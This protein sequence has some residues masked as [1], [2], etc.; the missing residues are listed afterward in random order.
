MTPLDYQD[1]AIPKC[2]DF[3]EIIDVRSPDEFLVDHIPGALNF[4]VLD[5]D[6]RKK[7]GTTY[8]QVNPFEAKKLGA[9]LIA[10]NIGDHVVKHFSYKSKNYKPYIYCW[11]GGQRSKSL[12]TILSA[13]GWRVALLR[14]GY[15]NYRSQVLD[16]FKNKVKHLSFII[17]G[18]VTGVG[19]TK[20]LNALQSMGHQVLD[21]EG[22]ANHK[23]SLLG[24]LVDI[25]QPHQKY[26]ESLIFQKLSSYEPT[27]PVWIESE[28][29]KIGDCSIP[30]CL[31]DVLKSCPVIE[32]SAPT[33]ERVQF[34]MDE[35][36]HYVDE[37][38]KLKNHLKTSKRFVGSGE[39]K[40][41]ELAINKGEIE[42]A[43]VILLESYYDPSYKNASKKWFKIPL[44]TVTA[45]ELNEKS[46][47]VIAQSCIDLLD[48]NFLSPNAS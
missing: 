42:K 20:V 39:Y 45:S 43:V 3:D 23:G 12:A 9:G 41:F 26:F 10:K 8:K 37:T 22:L 40:E 46:F 17:L 16:G 4:P 27:R 13:I 6:Q 30:P 38:D 1:I 24:G 14:G 2:Y 31:W 29:H 25:K 28:S 11:R 44:G 21:L 18:G 15:K 48:K 34:L 19:K 32:L 7:V 33:H 36:P 47:P 5:N 35:Y